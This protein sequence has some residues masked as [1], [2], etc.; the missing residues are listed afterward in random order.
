MDWVKG[1]IVYVD[2]KQR[3]GFVELEGGTQAFLDG[4]FSRVV[5]LVLNSQVEV[6]VLFRE[7]RA[8]KDRSWRVIDIRVPERTPTAE[9]IKDLWIALVSAG[10]VV[11]NIEQGSS[12]AVRL[13]SVRPDYGFPGS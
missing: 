4:K 6:Q 1:V 5:P 10:V 2:A 8:R 3:F 11:D 13:E 9:E 7:P 12:E